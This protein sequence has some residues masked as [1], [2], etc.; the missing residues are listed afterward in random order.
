M[1]EKIN[2]E[3]LPSDITAVCSDQV[4]AVIAYYRGENDFRRG[5]KE[6]AAKQFEFLMQILPMTSSLLKGKGYI[7]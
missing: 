3:N 2:V 6:Q 5:N 7:E 1:Q 4:R